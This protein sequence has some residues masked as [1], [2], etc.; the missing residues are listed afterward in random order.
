MGDHNL[1]LI[2][3]LFTRHNRECLSLIIRGLLTMTYIIICTSLLKYLYK[4]LL[5]YLVHFASL[6]KYKSNS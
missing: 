1:A 3:V 6:I 5:N 4:K 2:H